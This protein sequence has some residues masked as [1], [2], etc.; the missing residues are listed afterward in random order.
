MTL[1]EVLVAFAIAGLAV[2]SIVSGYLFCITSVE[3][4]AL[5][6]AANAKA[7]ERLEETRGAK[8]DTSSYPAVD[9][10][11]A[12]NFPVEVVVLDLAGSGPGVT[13]ATNLTRISQ[14]S[15]APPLKQ[16]RVDCIWRFKATQLVTNTI[17]TCR[18]P[19]Q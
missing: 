18:A 16:I 9:E 2:G 5:S 15:T 8:W 14:I 12:T 3:K 6:L 4:S 11:V 1:V 13:Y 19:D 17:E 10:L 7:T